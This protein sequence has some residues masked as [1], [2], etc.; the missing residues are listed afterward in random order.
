MK[1]KQITEIIIRN[2]FERLLNALESDV[3]IAG[4]GPS[5]LTAAFYLAKAG[6]KVVVLERKLSLGGGTWGGG[7]GFKFAVVEGNCLEILKDMGIRYK[8]E[9]A[10]LYSVDSIELA[11]GLIFSAL[12]A[13]AEIFN[14]VSVEDLVLSD[15]RVKGVVINS[16]PIEIAKL[17][18]D[19]ITLM[20]KAVV[21]ATGHDL[22]V[23][24]VLLRKNNVK[25]YTETGDILGERSMDAEEGERITVEK[26][27]EVFPGLYVAG[28][29]ACACFGGPRMG[30]IF[31]GMLLSGRKLAEILKEEV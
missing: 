6:K 3:I 10:D 30:P 27:G 9:G 26:T 11:S 19:P 16:S 7:M 28:M 12:Q 31:G 4:G 15:G 13:G 29:A 8:H 25:L 22:E 1:E 20:A 24:R 21:D 23:V 14:L 18:V 5:S 2:H 17:H